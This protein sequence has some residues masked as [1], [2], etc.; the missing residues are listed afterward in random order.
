MWKTHSEQI[1]ESKNDPKSTIMEYE[2]PLDF[3]TF[4]HLE[5]SKISF[6]PELRLR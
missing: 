5:F 2:R 3:S 4:Y 6:M 1:S